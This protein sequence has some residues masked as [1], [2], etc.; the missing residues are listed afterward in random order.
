MNYSNQS[1]DR[2]ES[3]SSHIDIII[4][5]RSKM[6]VYLRVKGD[7][8]IKPQLLFGIFLVQNML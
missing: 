1:F 4:A 7:Q 6:N 3:C 8:H 2:Q 5:I